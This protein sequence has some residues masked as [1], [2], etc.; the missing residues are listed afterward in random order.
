MDFSHA[1][2]DAAVLLNTEIV[3][4]ELPGGLDE[5]GIVQKDGAKD[6]P[7]RVQ[8]RGQTFLEDKRR[9]RHGFD[10]N[11]VTWRASLFPLLFCRSVLFGL[12]CSKKPS[13]ADFDVDPQ[14]I[15]EAGRRSRFAQFCTD[16]YKTSSLQFVL[17]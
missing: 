10:L 6:K 16:R 14:T 11:Q 3:G 8:I 2:E 13:R 17:H 7:F 15:E 12:S 9:R 4:L 1:G 5:I